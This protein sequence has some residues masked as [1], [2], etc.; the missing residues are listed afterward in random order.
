MEITRQIQQ[1]ALLINEEL[2]NYIKVHDLIRSE[3]ETFKSTIKNLFGFGTPMSKLLQEAEA[4]IPV[5]DSIES[6]L[7]NFK[8]L[9][10]S[11]LSEDQKHY[12]NLLSRFVTALKKTVSCLVSKQKLL[13]EGV[14]KFGSI[15]MKEQ[16]KRRS[17]YENSIEE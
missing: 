3:S 6:K 14:D 1:L 15:T 7:N 2:S 5:W 17:E 8:A 16:Q 11:L 13:A 10:Y 4:L 9:E 12:V